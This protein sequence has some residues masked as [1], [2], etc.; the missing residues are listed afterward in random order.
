MLKKIVSQDKYALIKK[1]ADLGEKLKAIKKDRS[2]ILKS[3]FPDGELT[4]ETVSATVRGLSGVGFAVVR[5]VSRKADY[6]A[7]VETD[8]PEQGALEEVKARFSKPFATVKV[9]L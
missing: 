6:K 3:F 7:I 4:E 2:E 5:T 1:Y 8:Y 9:K